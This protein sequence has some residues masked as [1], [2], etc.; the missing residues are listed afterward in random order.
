MPPYCTT[1]GIPPTY[2]RCTGVPGHDVH[3]AQC[4]GEEALGS[5][6]RLIMKKETPES[7]LASL[8][9]KISRNLC[10]EL[11]RLSGNKP[12]KDWIDEGSLPLYYLRLG[13]SA[14]SGVC[15]TSHPI[16][17]ECAGRSAPRC[18]GVRVNVDNLPP[19]GPGQAF[20]HVVYIVD[21]S[22]PTMSRRE[23]R[24]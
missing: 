4:P 2:T 21:Q 24:A 19:M 7:L 9:V 16:V 17:A 1:L 11:L 3:R 13:T 12:N 14:Q 23:Y 22:G 6:L 15:S 18:A 10:A 8:P 20:L 5:I